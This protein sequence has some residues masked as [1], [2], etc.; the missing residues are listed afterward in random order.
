VKEAAVDAD[1]MERGEDRFHKKFTLHTYRT[2]FTTLMRNQ[3]MKQRILRH[4]CNDTAS[5]TM[6]IYTR[7]NRKDACKEYLCCTKPLI[8]ITLTVYR[9]A[10]STGAALGGKRRE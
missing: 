1:V 7:V 8:M 9:R 2:G 4:I 5:E 3:G 6:G 10:L